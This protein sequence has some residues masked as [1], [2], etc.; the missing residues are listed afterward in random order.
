MTDKDNARSPLVQRA[1]AT[2]GLAHKAATAYGRPDLADR[3]RASGQRLADPSFQVLVVGE[4]K[5]GKSSL[6]NAL[7]GEDICP[8]DDDI[9]TAVPTLMRFGVR[10]RWQTPASCNAAKPATSA[11][12]IGNTSPM[13]TPSAASISAKVGPSAYS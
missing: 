9:A 11:R 1:L 6:V 4:F 8:V 3:L 7:L 12:T 5:Q 13:R 10:L 2:V